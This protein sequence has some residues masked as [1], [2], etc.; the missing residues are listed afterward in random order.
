MSH[1]QKIEAAAESKRQADLA[2]R[3]ATTTLNTLIVAAHKAGEGTT[4][5][6]KAAGYSTMTSIYNVL[7]AAG[8]RG[9]KGKRMQTT[10]ES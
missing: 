5:I 6:R 7:R 10:K 4:A 9:E 3:E 1:L 2:A 8:L